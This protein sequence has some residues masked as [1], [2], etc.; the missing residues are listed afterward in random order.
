MFKVVLVDDQP[1]ITQGLKAL[2]DWEDYGFEINYIAQDGLEALNY[3]K[4]NPVDL[5]ITDII[6]P[7]MTGLELIKEVKI[8]LPQL[9]CVILSGYQ[10]FDYIK[11]GLM[12]GIE[13]Y[14]VKPVDEEELLKTI[15]TIGE[16]LSALRDTNLVTES[17]TMKDNTLWRLLN[18]EIEKSEWSERLS[19]YDIELVHPFYNVSILTYENM[20]DKEIS[21]H[22]RGYIEQNYPAICLYS[23]DK[24]LIILFYED[25]KQSLLKWNRKLEEA[26]ISNNFSNGAFYVAMGMPV[27]SA[28]ELEESYL[29]AKEK[30]LLQ[31]YVNENTLIYETVN[32]DK[33]NLLKVQQNF[34]E[35]MIKQLANLTNH[36]PT[37]INDF[38]YILTKNGREFLSPSIAKNYTIELI[39]Y[40]HHSLQPDEFTNHA[41]A[42]EKI[43]YASSVEEM[44]GILDDYCND[45]ILSIQNQSKQRSPIVQ[46]VLDYIHTHYHQELS[47][48][49][50]G[51]RFHINAIY[52]G[53]LF[54]KEVGIVFSEYIN[55]YRLERAKELLK[56]TN[57]RAGE[58]GR[59]VGYSDTTY[60]YKQFKKSVGVTP[61]E[62]RNI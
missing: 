40:I 18:G 49:T 58:I 24:E 30:N 35:K 2:I 33:Q 15:Q 23:P 8:I 25:D 13:N 44:K 22:I 7:N 59:Q 38:Y 9:K 57:Y 5:L 53:Q 36:I 41:I 32:F 51:Q 42:I 56:T 14:L 48:K 45:L 3:L 37:L 31:V 46:N 12:L 61:T 29:N 55:R 27:E 50:L 21:N 4:T 26:M 39:A 10:E 60:F 62:W 17:S 19:L 28:D 47:L 43:V 11:Q 20:V 34:K 54:Q 6:M 1:I 16:K 52:L